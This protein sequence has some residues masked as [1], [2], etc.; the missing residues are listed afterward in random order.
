MQIVFGLSALLYSAQSLLP[1]LIVFSDHQHPNKLFGYFCNT[2]NKPILYSV[3][4]FFFATAKNFF[5]NPSKFI[6]QLSHP[7]KIPILPEH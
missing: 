1:E 5:A 3:P 6:P 4:M 2:P 7:N